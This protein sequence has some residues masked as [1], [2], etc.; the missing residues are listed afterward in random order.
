MIV[1][2]C[3]KFLTNPTFPIEAV[4]VKRMSPTRT[5]ISGDS[6]Y[7][8]QDKYLLFSKEINPESFISAGLKVIAPFPSETRSVSL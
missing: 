6:S 3:F 1:A 5:F 4:L 2:F 7:L 8:N